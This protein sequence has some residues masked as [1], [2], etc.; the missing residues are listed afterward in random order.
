MQEEK[1]MG[2]LPDT[3]SPEQAAREDITIKETVAQ[4][5]IVDWQEIPKNEIRQFG[6][7]N[8]DGAV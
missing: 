5:S 6:V 8:H 4:A 1:Y 2:A 3:R 7:Q